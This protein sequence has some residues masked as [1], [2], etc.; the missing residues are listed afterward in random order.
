MSELRVG[1]IG[2]GVGEQHIAGYEA[3]PAAR[4]TTLCD[5]TRRALPRWASAT[6]GAG[7]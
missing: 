5:S 2:L 7:S 6:P 4:V 1:I 3:H